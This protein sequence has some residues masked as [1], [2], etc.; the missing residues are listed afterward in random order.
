MQLIYTPEAQFFVTPQMDGDRQRLPMLGYF[1]SASTGLMARKPLKE[2]R[3]IAAQVMC[4]VQDRHDLILR[5]LRPF[6][7]SCG[8]NLF[9]GLTGVPAYEEHLVLSHL[10]MPTV[11]LVADFDVLVALIKRYPG[12][13]QDNDAVLQETT[14]AVFSAIKTVKKAARSINSGR[15]LG[16]GP[17][18]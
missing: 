5:K 2:Q 10:V 14:N 7:F 18:S 4:K 9:E 6:L 17:A 11:D 8:D 13:L 1:M 12:V 15:L 16:D 3:Q